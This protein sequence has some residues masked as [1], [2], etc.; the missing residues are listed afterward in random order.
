MDLCPEPLWEE[1]CRADPTCTFYQTPAWQRIGAR[2]YGAE[3][4]PLLFQCAGGPACLP[5]LKKKR[6][7][8]DRY[9]NPFGTYSSLVSAG[10][11]KAEDRAF[12]SRR[13]GALNLHLISSPFTRNEVGAGKVLRSRVQVIDLRTLDPENPMDRWHT[14]QRR[15]VRVG[16]RHGIRIRTAETPEEWERHYALYQLSLERWGRRA[17]SVY[18]PS[19]FED[20]R[21]SLSGTA[22]RR[23]W[24][25]EHRGEIGASCIAC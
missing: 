1:L 16:Q 19:L 13:L 4:T 6:W 5:L 17:T 25:V 2:Y 11:L 23:L 20:I 14:D 15:R 24:V 3:I 9:F 12:I 8:V 10:E 22:A 18:P 7:G 21:N